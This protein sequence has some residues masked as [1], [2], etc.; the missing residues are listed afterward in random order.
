MDFRISSGPLVK[1]FTESHFP[2][3]VF[4]DFLSEFSTEIFSIRDREYFSEKLL[5]TV[6]GLF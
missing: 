2:E 1:G 4:H 6:S 5:I 3:S